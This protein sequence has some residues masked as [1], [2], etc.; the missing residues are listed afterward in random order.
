MLLSKY[1]LINYESYDFRG[2]TWNQVQA[3]DGQAS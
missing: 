1:E 2:W 3:L